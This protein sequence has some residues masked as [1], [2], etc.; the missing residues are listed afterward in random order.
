M[1]TKMQ[2][3]YITRYAF[4]QGIQEAFGVIRKA[5]KGSRSYG[6]ECCFY[7]LRGISSSFEARKG[8]YHLTLEDAVAEA[9][10]MR[11]KEIAS[12]NRKINNLESKD[13]LREFLREQERVA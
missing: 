7:Q 6:H 12:L 5:P 13:F 11:T 1:S 3:V 8:Q 9:E 2:K 4:S 10:K